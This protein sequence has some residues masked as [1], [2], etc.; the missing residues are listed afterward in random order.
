MHYCSSGVCEC[1]CGIVPVPLPARVGS[2][3]RR[4][5]TVIAWMCA[6]W[7]AAVS[8]GL[9]P[10]ACK[11]S[12]SLERM[13]ALTTLDISANG[14]DAVPP[15][16]F[17]VSSLEAVDLSGAFTAS[18]WSG[19]HRDCPRTA[20]SLPTSGRTSLSSCDCLVVD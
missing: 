18:P 9:Q 15:A 4:P 8:R 16:V 13:T 6:I 3:E 19:L 1:G 5:A 11:L 20:V 10:C 14:F 12:L 17:G 7:L 2:R